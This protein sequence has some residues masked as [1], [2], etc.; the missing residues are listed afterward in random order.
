M[1]IASP[2][3]PCSLLARA[4]LTRLAGACE[5]VRSGL[6]C[7][8]GDPCSA[9]SPPR[10]VRRRPTPPPGPSRGPARAPGAI[11]PGPR[12]PAHN[13][14]PEA[15][16][17]L[18]QISSHGFQEAVEMFAAPSKF[19]GSRA[20][21]PAQ[22]WDGRLGSKSRAPRE[23]VRGE[24][25][26]ESLP[27]FLALSSQSPSGPAGGAPDGYGLGR[28]AAGPRGATSAARAR[29]ELHARTGAGDAGSTARAR[30]ERSYIDRTGRA[31]SSRPTGTTPSR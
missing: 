15:L 14:E 13:R 1:R 24:L 29:A 17:E 7:D 5:R 6:A 10:P 28:G 11:P 26:L 2:T 30:A 9:F 27:A 23:F 31:T 20:R 19:I 12:G 18:Q 25:R 22:R 4:V 8:T 21:D 16:P 3:R